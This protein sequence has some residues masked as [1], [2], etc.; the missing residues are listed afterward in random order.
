M[1]GKTVRPPTYARPSW[2]RLAVV[3]IL[4]LLMVLLVS[5]AALTAPSRAYAAESPVGLGATR[6]CSVLGGPAV[7]NT[8]PTNPD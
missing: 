5:L 3:V 6:T 1:V 4:A 2:P 8:E 7:T